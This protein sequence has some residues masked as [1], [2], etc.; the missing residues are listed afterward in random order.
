VLQRSLQL[1]YG[2]SVQRG[3]LTRAVILP[4]QVIPPMWDEI[5]EPVPAGMIV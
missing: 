5:P 1:Q 2:V 4:V 3:D